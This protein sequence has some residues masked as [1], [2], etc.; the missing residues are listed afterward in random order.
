MRVL[1]NEYQVLCC[2]APVGDIAAR[3]RKR[4]EEFSRVSGNS[5]TQEQIG[6]HWDYVREFTREI[7]S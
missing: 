4:Y 7:R 3:V 5:V 6:R 1:D 2:M